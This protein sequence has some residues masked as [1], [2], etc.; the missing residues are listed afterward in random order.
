MATCLQGN[1]VQPWCKTHGPS[2]LY[3]IGFKTHS[4]RYNPSLKFLMCL[5]PKTKKAMNLGANQIILLY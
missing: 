3:L 1:L 5:K 4:M 2:K